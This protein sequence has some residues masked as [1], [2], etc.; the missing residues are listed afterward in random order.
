MT[1]VR[2]P[3]SSV[4]AYLKVSKYISTIQFM[5]IL[6]KIF[7]LKETHYLIT[8]TFRK[9]KTVNKEKLTN[10]IATHQTLP[11]R[12]GLGNQKIP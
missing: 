1:G 12:L 7:S 6:V 8:R 2:T 11:K 3:S 10:Q 4:I 5:N 9:I